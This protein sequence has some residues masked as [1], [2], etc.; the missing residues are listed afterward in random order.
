MGKV[1]RKEQCPNCLDS[2]KDNL[3]IYDDESTYCFGCGYSSNKDGKVQAFTEVRFSALHTR[4]IDEETCK[5]YNYQIGKHNGEWVQIANYCTPEGKINF[6]KIRTKDKKMWSVGQATSQLYGSW[7]YPPNDKLFITVVEGELDALSVAQATGLQYPV[8]SVPNGAQAAVKAIE[9]NLQYLLGFKHVVLAFDNDEA[10]KKAMHSCIHLFEPGQL[11]IATWPLKDANEMLQ[12]GMVSEIKDTLF[13][14]KVIK[15]ESIVTISD[16]LDKVLVKPSSGLSYPWPSWTDA[17]YGLQPG[18]IHIVV[19]PP[20]VGKTEVIKE[21]IFH[22][23]DVHNYKVG[24]FSFEQTPDSTI[25]RLVGSKLKKKLHLPGEEWNEE[26]IRKTA[27]SF[28]EKLYLY[29]KA[30]R[31]DITD[32]F[33]S[34]RYLAKSKGCKLFVIDNIKALG[35]AT[36]VEAAQD[37]MNRLKAL[38]KETEA[39]VML[40]S[41]VS[42][43][44]FNYSTYVTTSPKNKDEYASKSA[45]ENDALIKKPGLEWESGR[46]AT[47]SS[48]EGGNIIVALADYVFGLARNR[49]SENSE[50][51]RILRVKVL[52]ARLDSSKD[53]KSFKL[54]YTDEGRLE[55]IGD[56]SASSITAF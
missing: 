17:T 51:Q 8:V 41:H 40:L 48:V 7:L 28:N 35:I 55:E 21:L 49:I 6:K 23:L 2:G 5:F 24:L 13:N 39:S 26:E 9:H 3:A 29:D 38:M 16:V 31:V 47:T 33:N 56:M 1:I 10:G 37:F 19:A 44:K 45:E 22:F 42:K 36:D 32:L 34:I 30:G 25:R 18:E 53:G 20:A 52:K 11:K 27:E 14:A 43:D 54:Y 4:S 12:V 50:E 15:P 46:M